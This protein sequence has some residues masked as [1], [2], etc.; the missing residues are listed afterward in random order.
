V[1][2]TSQFIPSDIKQVLLVAAVVPI[3][4][5]APNAKV[6]IDSTLPPVVAIVIVPVDVEVF[7]HICIIRPKFKDALGSVIVIATAALFT[8]IDTSFAPTV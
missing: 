1:L 5:V 3:V 6:V 7:L 4:V 8:N 2:N